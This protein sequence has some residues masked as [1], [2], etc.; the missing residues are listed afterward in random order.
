MHYWRKQYFETLKV[1]ATKASEF[2]EW[3][4]YAAFCLEYEGGLRKKAFALL[5]L[6]ISVYEHA[7]FSDRRRFTSWLLSHAEG[8]EGRHMLLPYPLNVR[9]IEPTLLEWTLV[10]PTCSKPHR[11][12]GGYEHLQQAIRLDPR[13]D[14]ARRKLILSILSRVSDA[15]HELPRGYL[16]DPTRDL[17]ALAE[18]EELVPALQDEQMR[19]F[20][21]SQIKFDRLLIEEYLRKTR[22]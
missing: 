12:L 11:W 10:E 7:P 9:L 17:A 5:D 21:D 14:L 20:W 16:G 4:D 22:F 3:A 19:S 1:V 8:R 6:F 15:A 18:A 13:D 2:P